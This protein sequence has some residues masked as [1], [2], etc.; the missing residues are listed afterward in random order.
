MTASAAQR[1][2]WHA[3]LADGPE[4][5]RSSLDK[6]LASRDFSGPRLAGAMDD[7]ID[8]LQRLNIELNGDPPSESGPGAVSVSRKVAYAVT[9]ITRALREEAQ[10]D[11]AWKVDVAWN[12]ILAGDI[13]DINSHIN[14]ERR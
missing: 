12:A 8:T 2:L 9:E 11:A 4:D 13:D 14:G 7:L 10:A 3:G 6:C 1:L 5:A